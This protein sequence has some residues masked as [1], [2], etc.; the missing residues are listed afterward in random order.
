MSTPD[1]FEEN[2]I[3]AIKKWTQIHSASPKVLMEG[4]L[5]AKMIERPISESVYGE[6]QTG[7]VHGCILRAP[8]YEILVLCGDVQGIELVGR[9][10]WIGDP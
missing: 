5:F 3:A 7:P 1:E 10:R 4:S 8:P 6:F 9:N 2:L